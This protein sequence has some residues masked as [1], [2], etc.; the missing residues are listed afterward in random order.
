M[1]E[2]TPNIRQNSINSG[3]EVEEESRRVMD[4][5]GK[6]KESTYLGS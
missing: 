3:E 1:K 4:T 5:T 2:P 6:P